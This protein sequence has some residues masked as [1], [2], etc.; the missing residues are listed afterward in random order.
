MEVEHVDGGECIEIDSQSMKKPVMVNR[1][2]L[3]STVTMASKVVVQ[4]KIT[5]PAGDAAANAVM[6]HGNVQGNCAM[7]CA[8][9]S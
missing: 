9:G 1:D 6:V 8:V 4:F 3:R 5:N 2:R 7:E